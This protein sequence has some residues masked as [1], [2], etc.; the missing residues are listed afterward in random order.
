MS[1]VWPHEVGV[2]TPLAG[3]TSHHAL[4]ADLR[5]KADAVGQAVDRPQGSTPAGV[6]APSLMF[7]VRTGSDAVGSTTAPPSPP[8]HASV[9]TPSSTPTAHL[10]SVAAVGNLLPTLV[11]GL[12]GCGCPQAGP[13]RRICVR[14]L[15]SLD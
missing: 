1:S 10:P 2:L 5:G 15:E 11:S 12:R 8:A 7:R 13:A 6:P 4:A 3:V 14:V 9:P